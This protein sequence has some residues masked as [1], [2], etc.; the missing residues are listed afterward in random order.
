MRK[1]KGIFL[2]IAIQA[3][4][5]ELTFFSRNKERV[6]VKWDIV[7]AAAAASP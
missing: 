4:E 3:E 1:K 6:G 7:L 5:K 2:L